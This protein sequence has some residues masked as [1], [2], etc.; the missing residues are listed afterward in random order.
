MAANAKSIDKGYTRR[1]ALN[2]YD[3]IR[4]TANDHITGRAAASC[5]NRA[6]LIESHF[7][8]CLS[9]AGFQIALE[10]H[11]AANVATRYL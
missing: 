5:R 2:K 4:M 6:G 3:T 11:Y 8:R 1:F 10:R 9:C 7:L